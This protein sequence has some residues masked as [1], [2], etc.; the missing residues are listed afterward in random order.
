MDADRLWASP[1]RRHG[2]RPV[3]RDRR[4]ADGLGAPG[5]GRTG[6]DR[7]GRRDRSAVGPSPR[8]V[9]AARVSG[10]EIVQRFGDGA[11]ILVAGGAG[12]VPS[13]VV[14]RLIERGATVVAVDNFVT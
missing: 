14:D 3:W 11:R 8:K 12:F 1:E 4:A 13:H 10:V 9:R 2:A 7:T 5:R 6:P